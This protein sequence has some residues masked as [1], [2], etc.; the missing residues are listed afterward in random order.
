MVE[1][2]T[3]GEFDFG[4]ALP[5]FLRS[6]DEIAADAPEP[7]DELPRLYI[8]SRIDLIS[9]GMGMWWI[10]LTAGQSAA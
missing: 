4:L 1:L 8:V 3:K 9:A 10:M 6:K 2:F 7:L 5:L